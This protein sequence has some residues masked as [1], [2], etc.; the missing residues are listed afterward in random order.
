MSAGLEKG[1]GDRLAGALAAAALILFVVAALVDLEWTTGLMNTAF[2]ATTRV[3]GFAWQLLMFLTLLV[4]LA[5]AVSPWGAIRLGGTTQPEI[6][7]PRWL[8][9]ILCTLLAGGGV[10]WSAAEPMYHFTTPPP[11]FGAVPAGSPA[12]VA[13]ALAQSYLHWGFLAWGVV[14][15]LGAITLSVVHERGVPLTPRAL[16]A[17]W[18]SE[19]TLAGPLG[20]VIDALA[21]VAALAGTIGPIGFLGLQLAYAAKVLVGAPDGY[22]TQ[23]FVLGLLVALATVSAVSG[24]DRGIQI[25]SRVNVWLALVLA[26]VILI[27]GPTGF[28]FSAFFDA[29]GTY[30]VHFPAMA[31]YDKDPEWLGF[32]TV[33]YWGWFLS[34]GPLMS[35][36]VARISRGRSI[37]EVVLGV[38]VVAPLLTH[39]WFTVL[40]GSGVA[41]ELAEPG[42]VSAALQSDGLPAALLAIVSQL[43]LSVVL[44]PAFV[45]LIFVFLA[46]S[47]DSMAYTASMIVSGKS[48]PPPAQRAF[49]SIAMGGVAAVLLLMGDGGIKALQSAIVIAAVPVAALMATCVVSAPWVLWRRGRR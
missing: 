48:T 36:F 49:W 19:R 30:L 35:I 29:L 16:L 22:L 20:S 7:Y 13:P 12:A 46:T 25:L 33:F 41:F 40:G 45:V 31:L 37:R 3:F 9:I 17:G 10:F 2:G 34:Y 26:A 47:A 39:F 6:P 38:A 23:L 18:L 44:L 14:G 4:A 1:G 43:P 32:W 27:L 28:I 11:L 8:A 24:I 21:I 5:I 15:T 42:S